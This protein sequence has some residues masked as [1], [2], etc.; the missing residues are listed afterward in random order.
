MIKPP[1]TLLELF[2]SLP[3]RTLVQLIQNEIVISPSPIDPHQLILINL[4][5]D[6]HVFVKQH[7][8]GQVRVAP[9]DVHLNNTNIYQPDIYF[10]STKNLGS[11]KNNG[12]HGAPDLVVEILSPSTA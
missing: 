7:K 2:Q 9:S 6:M 10:V 4:G 12:F 5:S 1:R 3:Q 11:L 8:L